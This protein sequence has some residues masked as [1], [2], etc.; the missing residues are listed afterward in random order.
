MSREILSV[1]FLRLA[2]QRALRRRSVAGPFAVVGRN[3]GSEQVTCLSMAASRAGLQAGMGLADARAMCPDLT[4]VPADPRGDARFLRMLARWA[5][6]YCPWVGLEGEDGL[7]MDITGS[8]HLMGGPEALMADLRQR[9]M[10]AGFT[11]RL[12]VAPT[13]GAAW[14]LARYD[15]GIAL[16]DQVRARLWPLPVGALRL[17]DDVIEGLA[18]LGVRKVADLAALP[19]ATVGRRFG[20]EP[21]VRL[22]QALGGQPE[23]ITPVAERERPASRLTLAEP[24]GRTDDVMEGVRHLLGQLCPQL[25]ESGEGARTLLLTLRRVDLRD[26]SV[27]LRLARPMRKPEDIAPLFAKGVDEIDAGYGIDQ[28]RLEATVAE[29]LP[30]EQVTAH[31]VPGDIARAGALAD[32]M[33]RL[34]GRLGLENVLR[35]QPAESHIPERAFSTA[36]AAWSEPARGWPDVPRAR[37]VLIFAPEAVGGSGARAVPRRFRWRRMDLHL[38]EAEGPERIAPEWWLDDPAWRSGLRDYWRV[39]TREGWR[40]WMFHTPQDPAWYV[41]G[42]F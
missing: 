23:S 4:T 36:A 26:A 12:G 17:E 11:V 37:P 9:L 35:W 10:R 25:E 28:M 19:R 40:L 14:A 38:L 1:W 13:R 21:L 24:I 18:R 34:G 15:E 33:T 6:R 7:V 8:S 2:S 22:D 42:L 30:P 32:L 29:A 41:Q 27:E 16:G 39:Q 5:G 31:S 20:Q 3:R